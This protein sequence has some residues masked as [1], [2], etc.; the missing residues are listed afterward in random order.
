MSISAQL[1]LAAREWI[2]AFHRRFYGDPEGLA[3]ARNPFLVGREIAA[4]AEEAFAGL[5]RERASRRLK[6]EL[7]ALGATLPTLYRQYVELCEP[8]GV[9]F[10]DFGVDPDFG[11]CV[12]GLIVVDL[13]YLKAVKRNRYLVDPRG[14]R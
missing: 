14:A 13:A 5:D 3:R 12:D 8:E 6:E 11:G 1:P 7:A 2:V 4:R 9:R 10:L